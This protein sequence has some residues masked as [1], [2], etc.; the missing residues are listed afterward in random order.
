MDDSRARAVPGVRQIV[1][2]DDLV[3]VVGD[4]MWAAKTGLEALDVTWD[5][6]PNAAVSTELIWS[7]LRAA[8]KRDGSVAKQVGDV[9]RRVL[10]RP[11]R[12]SDE[13]FTAEFEMP[14]LA[15]ACMEPL[16]CTVHMTATSA[17]AWIGTQ[18]VARVQAAV[19][20]AA[21]LHANK[22]SRP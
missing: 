2:L 3:A 15:H 5:D 20:K 6:G 8:S 1:V 17:E 16:N 9:E 11:V 14:L 7:R 18:V 10:A 12:S 21:G 22:V 4:H 19:A 13:I